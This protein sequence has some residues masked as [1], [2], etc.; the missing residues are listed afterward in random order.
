LG[1]LR[2]AVLG[3]AGHIDH[4]KT[5]LIKTLTGIDTDRLAEEKQRGISIELGFAHL[6]LPS[7]TELGIVDVPG[8]ER[9]VKTMLAGVGGIDMVL[10]V[11]A[12]DEGVM[13]QTV[14]HLQIVDLLGIGAGVVVL[15]KTDLVDDPEWM[16]LVEADVKKLLEATRLSGAP[17]VKFS[18]VTGEG[19]GELLGELDRVAAGIRTKDESSPSRLPVDRVFSVAG[20]GTVVT[21]TLWSGSF[22]EGDR[23]T[24]LPSERAGRIRSIEVHSERAERAVAGQRVALSLPGLDTGSMRRGDWVTTPGAFGVTSRLD[25][26]LSVLKSHARGLKHGSRVRFHLGASEVLGRV[27]MLDADSIEAG[28]NGYAQLRFEG[29]VVAKAGDLFVLRSYSPMRTIAGGRVV[30]PFPPRHKRFRPE[31]VHHLGLLDRGSP[32]ERIEAVLRERGWMGMSTDRLRLK[33]SLWGDELERP[34]EE[35][36]ERGVAVRVG[37]DILLHRDARDELKKEVEQTIQRYQSEFPLRWGIP[38]GEIR[39]KLGGKAEPVVLD[40]ILSELERTGVAALRSGMVR[41]GG[42]EVVLDPAKAE[43]QRRLEAHLKQQGFSPALLDELVEKFGSDVR[44]LLE[45][46]QIE[47]KVCKVTSQL[48]LP[49]GKMEQIKARVRDHFE[50]NP[51]MKVGDFKDMFSISRKYAVPYL[52]YLDRNG[53]TKRAGD[54]YRVAGPRLRGG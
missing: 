41:W 13:P 3:T 42:R 17:V 5:A 30:D 20:F 54:I 24:V 48:W 51:K 1:S 21:G 4:G 53:Y 36:L 37:S 6:T 16:A 44:E 2:R 7:G 10:L 43:L 14:E 46:M 47:G 12:A 39:S 26:Y 33:L 31:V 22:A 49:G 34:L 38:A 45:L 35:L 28:E 19:T 8:H 40:A 29:P 50:S 23:V 27:V 52:E 32:A 18:A 11:V 15:T 25:C 9:F